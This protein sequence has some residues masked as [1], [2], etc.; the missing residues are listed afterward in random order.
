MEEKYKKY[1]KIIY[2]LLII[3]LLSFEVLFCN[4]RFVSSLISF[5]IPDTYI[6]SLPRLIVYI[7]VIIICKYSKDRIIENRLKRVTKD[8]K[9]INIIFSVLFVAFIG[10]IVGVII[11]GDFNIMTVGVL[12]IIL[13]YMLFLYLFIGKSYK[14]NIMLMCLV[15]L[16]NSVGVKTLHILDEVSHTPTTYNIAHLNFSS[17]KVYY[18]EGLAKMIPLSRY[19]DN[20]DLFY[21]YE[22]QKIDITNDENYQHFRCDRPSMFLH[23]PSAIGMLMGEYLG[24]TV[25]DMFYLGRLFAAVTFLFLVMIFLKIVK[26]KKYALIGLLSTP[27]TLTLA[28]T[29]S[30]DAFGYIFIALFIAYVLNIYHDKDIKTIT[31]KQLLTIILLFLLI[32]LFKGATYILASFM[33]ILIIKKFNFKQK[34]IFQFAFF[35][36]IAFILI[37][38]YLTMD[39][40]VGDTRGGDT[41]MFGALEF[42][43]SSP[44]NIAIVTLRHI[45]NTIFNPGYYN[46]LFNN[47]FFGKYGI[48]FA[49]PYLL[50][51]VFLSLNDEISKMGNKI[52]YILLFVGIFGVTSLGIYLSFTPVGSLDVKGYQTRYIIQFLPFL[53]FL[54]PNKFITINLDTKKKE[55]IALMFAL[56]MNVLLLLSGRVFYV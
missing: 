3:A 26:F 55:N 43:L 8:Q 52:L 20:D 21:S 42:L 39:M 38:V 22:K 28:G 40:S 18:N 13:V 44:K 51:L 32:A 49:I 46:S 17:S 56:V 53:L 12:L 4:S 31:N 45:S 7:V 41:S 37:N 14:I 47:A 19:Y 1:T 11:R 23:I 5:K 9:L 27:L 50:Y 6:F 48:I 30:C 16:I 36:I 29:Y 25:M 15:V 54:I 35:A 24:G 10:C 2:G 34:M 33:L